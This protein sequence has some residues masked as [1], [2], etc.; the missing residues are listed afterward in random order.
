MMPTTI[1]QTTGPS[2]GDI[3]SLIG[4]GILL[5]AGYHYVQY[6]ETSQTA[7][8]EQARKNVTIAIIAFA[9]YSTVAYLYYGQA[10]SW[11][12]QIGR[13]VDLYFAR[14]SESLIVDTQMSGSTTA[15]NSIIEGVRTI[16]LIA[17]VLVF[18]AT[19]ILGKAPLVVLD[20]LF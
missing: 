10:D 20:R 5:V 1:L 3:L 9:F 8:R 11:V 17:Y 14:M 12:I 2:M 4:I 16:G 19:S 7:E 15:V 18:A 6:R 13:S